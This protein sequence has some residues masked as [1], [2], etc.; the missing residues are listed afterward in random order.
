M[1]HMQVVPPAGRPGE[2]YGDLSG[3]DGNGRALTTSHMTAAAVRHQVALVLIRT[4]AANPLD[5]YQS[6]EEDSMSVPTPAS[7]DDRNAA[8]DPATSHCRHNE[9]LYRL[10]TDLDRIAIDRNVSA[11]ALRVYVVLRAKYVDL[12][13][14]GW[15]VLNDYMVDR[16]ED[17]ITALTVRGYLDVTTNPEHA[18]SEYADKRLL[19]FTDTRLVGGDGWFAA[20]SGRDL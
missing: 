8:H 9:P 6:P 4:A 13:L 15:H 10:A 17:E 16:Y 20:D 5:P 7:D 1:K 2:R 18:M 19:R 3:T 12:C 14:D 11:E